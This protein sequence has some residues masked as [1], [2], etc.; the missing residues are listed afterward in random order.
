[1][2]AINPWLQAEHVAVAPGCA[3]VVASGTSGYRYVWA[4]GRKGARWHLATKGTPEG[5]EVS[6]AGD[7]V[8]IGTANG[9]IYL[10]SAPGEV[11]REVEFGWGVTSTIRFSGDSDCDTLTD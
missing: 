10:V 8:A 1:M 3:W 7:L 9:R 5:V 6:R 4:I 2:K 11:L